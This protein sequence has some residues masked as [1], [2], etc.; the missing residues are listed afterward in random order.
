MPK[1]LTEADLADFKVTYRDPSRPTKT[2]R[3]A[4]A[5]SDQAMPYICSRS[6]TTSTGP[7]R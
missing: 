1:E 4:Y 2:V 3:A 5:T 6:R 7:S